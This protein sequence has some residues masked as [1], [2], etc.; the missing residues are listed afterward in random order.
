MTTSEAV[1]E[2]P[3]PLS[4]VEVAVGDDTTILVR[5]HGTPDGPRLVM[6]H[7]N[8]LAIDLYYPFWSLLMGD[9]DLMVY[10]LRNHGRNALGPLDGH[11][12]PTLARDQDIVLAAI[13]EHYGAK[14]KVGV[15]HSISALATLMSP[16]NGGNLA[17]LVLFDPPLRKPG[18]T[19]DEYDDV[20]I[21]MAALA[22]Q[23][24][25]HFASKQQFMDLASFSPNFRGVVPG[26]LELLAETTLRRVADEDGYELSCPREY[27]AQM[28]E[29]ARIFA[30]GVD[31]LTYDS[32]VKVVGADPTLPYS[33]LPTLDFSE[34]VGVDYDFLPDATHFLQLEQPENCVAVMREFLGGLGT[35]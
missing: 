5:R 17:A 13:D 15:F 6:S 20:A 27:E 2:V 7:G 9:F 33:Y 14:P 19:H 12:V 31:L 16:S 8:G 21:R 30:I 22:R 23:R 35:I 10:D 34:M 28:I 3:E 29:Y 24:M 25:H 26:V 32:P 11:N 1:W 4:T 18:F